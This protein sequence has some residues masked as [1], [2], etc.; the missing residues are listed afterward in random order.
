MKPVVKQVRAKTWQGFE[1][2]V[3]SK[4]GN[5]GTLL[6][7]IDKD[8]KSGY[9]YAVSHANGTATVIQN[10][11]KVKGTFPDAVNFRWGVVADLDPLTGG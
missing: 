5:Y 4:C 10:L 9:T 11:G 8:T 1:A 3:A 7:G 6:L 2:L